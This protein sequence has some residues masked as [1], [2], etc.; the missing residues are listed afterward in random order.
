MEQEG[1]VSPFSTRYASAEMQH[2]FSGKYRAQLWRKLWV[3]LAEA[4]H[5][6]GLP[7]SEEQI[8]EMQT[9]TNDVDMDA[10]AA[11]E[12]S[13]RHDVMAHIHAYADQCPLAAPIIHLGATSCYVGDNSDSLIVRQ[14]L[15]LIHAKLLSVLRPLHDFACK[16]KDLPTL[17][18][19]HFQPAQPTT[20]GKRACLWINDLVSDIEECEILLKTQKPLGCKG[21]TGTQASF[22]DLFDGDYEKVRELERIIVQKMGFEKAQYVSGQTYSR[23]WDGRVLSFLAQVGVTAHKFAADLRLLAHE[24]ELE[25]PFESRQIGSSAMP[26][27]RNPMRSERMSGLSRYL[28]LNAQNGLMTA[29]EQWL[30]R[31]LDDSANRRISLSEG[32]LCADAVLA[33]FRNIVCGLVVHEKVIEK[34]LADELPFMATENLLME[35]VRQGGNRQ[36]L[37]EKIRQKSL[38]AGQRVKEEGLPPAL[39]EDLAADEDF[40]LTMDQIQS[41]LDPKLYT[42][43]AAQQTEAFLRDVVDPILEKYSQESAPEQKIEL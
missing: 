6:L 40:P 11:Y 12:K 23:K 24:K 27:K 17:S 20:V 38:K 29:A 31:S 18:Y 37:H 3:I 25:E 10:A 36:L 19:T 13:L 26:Y 1:Y 39:L 34:H 28:I 9:H 32:F 4:E 16:Y 8:Q 43:C 2:L 30:E 35:A 15:E 5:A 41:R 33:L 7:V 21:A 14:A 22:L 42:G